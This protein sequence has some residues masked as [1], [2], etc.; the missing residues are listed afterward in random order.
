MR[1]YL[2][3]SQHE[4]TSLVDPKLGPF[5]EGP[6]LLAYNDALFTDEDWEGI[7]NL[8]CSI[9]AEDPFKVG[10]FGIGFNSIYHITGSTYSKVSYRCEDD[11]HEG[12]GGGGGE[13]LVQFIM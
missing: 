3:N 6:A 12:G 7:Q 2:D 1:F 5:Y 10:K 4:T 11:V 8:E 13:D 9:K